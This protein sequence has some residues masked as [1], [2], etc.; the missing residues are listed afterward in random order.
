M[1]YASYTDQLAGRERI[2]GVAYDLVVTTPEYDEIGLVY[3]IGTGKDP[4]D[5]DTPEW[6][7]VVGDD[8][9]A[10]IAEG[11]AALARYE[12]WKKEGKL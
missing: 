11:V 7:L 10:A 2:T 9:V 12:A 5:L 8:R 3:V 4:A 6:T 1:S